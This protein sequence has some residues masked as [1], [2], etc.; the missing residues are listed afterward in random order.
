MRPTPSPSLER[1]PLEANKSEIK[2]LIKEP[3]NTLLMRDEEIEFNSHEDIDDLVPIPRV[4]EKSLDSLD[5]ILETFKTTITDPLFDFDSEF[6]LNSDNPILDIQN[7]ESDESETETIMDELQ[8]NSTQT[9]VQ[10]PPLYEK[11]NFDSTMPKPILTFLHFRYGIFG[12]HRV[13]DILGPRLPFS[14]S[15]NFSLVFSKEYLKFLLLNIFLLGDENTVF[16]PGIIVVN[17][18]SKV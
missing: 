14:L 11:L 1:E 4:S 6:T 8:I 5:L 12:S 10:I 17:I 2:P 18:D 9:T 16:D 7:K 15:Y 3:P 13:F